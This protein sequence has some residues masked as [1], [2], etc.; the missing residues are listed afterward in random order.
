MTPPT[1]NRE[2]GKPVIV[3]ITEENIDRTSEAHKGL[4]LNPNGTLSMTP[5]YVTWKN[6]T[7]MQLQSLFK[8]LPEFPS[9]IN[10]MD[11]PKVTLLNLKW[12]HE[13]EWVKVPMSKDDKGPDYKDC[14]IARIEKYIDLE[15]RIRRAVSYGNEEI[16][17]KV[18]FNIED[19]KAAF[20]NWYIPSPSPYYNGRK[21]S[22]GQRRQGKGASNPRPNPQSRDQSANDIQGRK[23][24]QQYYKN[25][26]YNKNQPRGKVETY[27]DWDNQQRA[28]NTATKDN[29]PWEQEAW[30][31]YQQET[32]REQGARPK[33]YQ[34]WDHSW[35]Q[36]RDQQRHQHQQYTGP[37]RE[38]HR[39][40]KQSRGSYQRDPRER[41]RDKGYSGQEYDHRDPQEGYYTRDYEEK[42]RDQSRGH[43]RE[44]YKDYR[45][46]GESRPGHREVSRDRQ[47]ERRY[48]ERSKSPRRQRERSHSPRNEYDSG[49]GRGG[50]PRDRSYSPRSNSGRGRGRSYEKRGSDASYGG[51]S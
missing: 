39:D 33:E 9:G 15:G 32:T 23:G 51:N 20:P 28:G 48:R 38:S 30:E 41:S 37:P 40:Q 5:Q 17:L 25:K 31:K 35:D 14:I 44:D 7:G 16:K 27:Q 12:T 36:S 49:I 10:S 19:L 42:K 46:R 21:F 29:Q 47:V 26:G 6:N 4:L 2:E 13:G 45:Q 11:H 43:Y 1:Q 8:T 3:T 34:S 24:N 18:W 22:P 50:R